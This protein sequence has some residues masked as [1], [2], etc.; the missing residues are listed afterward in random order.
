[1][2]KYPYS[3]KESTLVQTDADKADYFD[4]DEGDQFMAES[5]KEAENEVA[6]KRPGVDI[7]RET[8]DKNISEAS[9]LEEE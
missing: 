7:L 9:K 2:K 6:K 4:D 8:F 5:I 1:M 3:N